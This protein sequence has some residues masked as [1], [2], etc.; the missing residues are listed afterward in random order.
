MAVVTSLASCGA[1]LICW[2]R[3]HSPRGQTCIRDSKFHACSLVPLCDATDPVRGG[4]NPSTIPCFSGFCKATSATHELYRA[5]VPRWG[6]AGSKR[7]HGRREARLVTVRLLVVV[8]V[9]AIV[10]LAALFP[11]RYLYALVG[12]TFAERRA[13]ADAGELL[14]R[15]HL[16]RVAKA[17]G[18]DGR[19][20]CVD[21]LARRGSVGWS[22]RHSNVH[23]RKTQP[24]D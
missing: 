21:P 11:N 3:P 22:R 19:L 24:R 23:E 14:G 1:A 17:R 8:V 9:S 6:A 4:H 20:A 7:P 12:K 2:A 15:V 13:L 16:E 18:Q 5:S 10:A